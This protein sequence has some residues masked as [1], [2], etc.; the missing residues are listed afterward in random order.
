MTIISMVLLH[1]A[2]D[3][4][5]S[6]SDDRG[7]FT[8]DYFANLIMILLAY[9]YCQELLKTR[10]PRGAFFGPLWTF[11]VGVAVLVACTLVFSSQY[12]GLESAA[13]AIYGSGLGAALMIF[14]FSYQLRDL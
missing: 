11:L 8:L 10:E 2:Y 6:W 14:L 5:L 3:F 12:H 1:G 13:K 9:A 7:I 4:C